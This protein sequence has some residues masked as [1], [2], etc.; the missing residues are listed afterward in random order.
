MTSRSKSKT[1]T[2]N[3]MNMQK[4]DKLV[5]RKKDPLKHMRKITYEYNE[6]MCDGVALT[7]IEDSASYIHNLRRER[8]G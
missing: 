1:S 4:E 5:Y 7:R 3:F 2:G 6:S 8:N